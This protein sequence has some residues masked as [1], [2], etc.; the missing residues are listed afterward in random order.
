MEVAPNSVRH[1]YP[2]Y[3]LIVMAAAVTHVI[4]SVWLTVLTAGLTVL[5]MVAEGG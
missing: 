3:E 5:G 1:T 4:S 2:E